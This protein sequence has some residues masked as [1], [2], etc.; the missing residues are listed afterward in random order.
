[1]SLR[2]FRKKNSHRIEITHDWDKRKIQP[3][4]IIAVVAFISPS[5]WLKSLHHRLCVCFYRLSARMPYMPKWCYVQSGH[6]PKS[7]I[8][9]RLDQSEADFLELLV[10][11]VFT[12]ELFCVTMFIVYPMEILK[13]CLN[14][15]S[16]PND[17]F[18]N[19][20]YLLRI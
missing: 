10:V 11:F 1:M 8:A 2:I 12:F 15:A 4:N 20:K 6:T 5:I 14:L 17:I 18:F 9:W 3:I 16:N 19:H 13:L 7:C